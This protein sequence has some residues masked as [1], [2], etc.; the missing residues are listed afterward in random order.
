VSF[1]PNQLENGCY[2]ITLRID[3]NAGNR[4]DF[5]EKFLCVGVAGGGGQPNPNPN[6]NPQPQPQPQPP[7]GGGGGG[8]TP[9]P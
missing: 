3:T 7:A 9:I 4:A 5:G 1:R 6:P 8:T 2:K